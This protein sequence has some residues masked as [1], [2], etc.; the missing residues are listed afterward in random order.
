M[1]P[2]LI[3]DDHPIAQQGCQRILEDA[4]IASIIHPSDAVAGYELF[5]QLR[6]EVVII[7][8]ALSGDG[9]AGLSL[10]RR[11]RAQNPRVHLLVFTMHDDPTIVA[12]SLEAGASGYVVKDAAPDELIKAVQWTSSTI[13]YLSAKL[14]LACHCR[15]SSAVS[16]V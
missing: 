5:R 12:Q 2:V 13:P 10:V 11:M 3:I 8:L 1:R 9:L 6:P 15:D 7:D 16:I 14:A 4:G